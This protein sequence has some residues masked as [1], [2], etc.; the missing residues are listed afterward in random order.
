MGAEATVINT[1]KDSMQTTK[2]S[3][4]FRKPSGIQLDMRIHSQRSIAEE[5]VTS[6]GCQQKPIKNTEQIRCTSLVNDEDNLEEFI[7]KK[8]PS[9]QHLSGVNQDEVDQRISEDHKQ[10]A[11]KPER[12]QR[13]DKRMVRDGGVGRKRSRKEDVGGM[14]RRKIVE[15]GKWSDPSAMAQVIKP[16]LIRSQSTISQHSHRSS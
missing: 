2:S 11:D 3:E 12:H 8:G 6:Q 1:C 9:S 4:E 13:K 15:E 14:S 7:L 5:Q 10:G 16:C